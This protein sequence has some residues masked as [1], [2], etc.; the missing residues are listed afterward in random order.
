[1]NNFMKCL[2]D[3]YTGAIGHILAVVFLLLIFI[4]DEEFHCSE[5][6]VKRKM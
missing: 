6:R 2:V 3:T 4:P 5:V 1:M